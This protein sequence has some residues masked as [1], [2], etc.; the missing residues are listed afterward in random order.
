MDLHSIGSDALDDTLQYV[1]AE[2][3]NIQNMASWEMVFKW[4]VFMQNLVQT[5]RRSW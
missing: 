3:E 1:L 2:E 4:I 5:I